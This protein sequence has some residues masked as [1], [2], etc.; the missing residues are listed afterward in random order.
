MELPIS[1]GKLVV[2][3]MSTT[4]VLGMQLVSRVVLVVLVRWGRFEHHALVLATMT[5][6][7]Y[8]APIPP[9]NKMLK[10]IGKGKQ[11]SPNCKCVYF[12]T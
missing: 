4:V 12:A 6:T 10:N 7:R 1:M 8:A 11:S 9:E 3:A 5:T 2:I